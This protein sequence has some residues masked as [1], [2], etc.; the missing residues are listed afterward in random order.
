LILLWLLLNPAT[1]L[2][3][4]SPLT[5][6]MACHHVI[7]AAG[8]TSLPGASPL[9]SAAPLAAGPPPPGVVVP[10]QAAAAIVNASASVAS[11]RIFSSMRAI[12]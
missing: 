11:L 1:I 8:A 7:V 5:P 6:D 2:L 3:S 9:M 12:P 10:P 4:A